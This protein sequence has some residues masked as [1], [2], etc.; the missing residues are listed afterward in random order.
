[1]DKR[2]FTVLFLPSNPSRV[3][4]LILSEFLIK[5][6][7]ISAMI[8]LLAS[9]AIFFDYVNVKKKEVDLAGLK[10][11]TKIQNVQLQTFADKINDMEAELARLRSLDTKIRVLTDTKTE[12]PATKS[13]RLSLGGRGGPEVAPLSFDREALLKDM[14]AKLDRL[15]IEAKEQEKSLHELHASIRDR[16]SLLAATPSLWPVRG[17]ISSRFGDRESPFDSSNEF[18]E[19]MDISAPSGS[20]VV[21]AAEGLVTFAARN[22]DLGNAVTIDHGYGIVSRYG[23]LSEI[24]V[25]IGQKVMAGQRIGAVGSTGRST[26]PHLHYEVVVNGYKVNPIKYLN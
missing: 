14:V 10:E 9:S 17:Y 23:H 5:S 15:N 7:A 3:K 18:H 25:R 13:E 21:A 4:K 1:M 11:Q 26:G 2:F 12:G 6:L 22:N 19:G 16:E 24:S 8:L 20:A